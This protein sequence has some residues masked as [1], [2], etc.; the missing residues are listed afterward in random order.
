M[1][2][3]LR[4]RLLAA[5]GRVAEGIGSGVERPVIIVGTGRCGTTLLTDILDSHPALLGYPDEAN[6]LWHPRTYPFDASDVAPAPIE[7]DPEGFTRLSVS[8]W[9]AGHGRTIRR[10]F[11]G[12]RFM[13]GRSKALFVKSAMISFMIPTIQSIFPDLKVIHLYR[14]G[15]SVV[16]SYMKKN[17]GRYGRYRPAEEEYRRLC[18]AY[19]HA[20]IVEIRRACEEAGLGSDRFHEFSYEGLCDD[21][22]GTVDEMAGFLGID[23]DAVAYDLSRIR[24]TNYKVGDWASDPAWKDALAEMRPTM[25]ALG[26]L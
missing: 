17:Y 21:A 1:R 6:D 16:A 10:V 8:Q 25:E 14:N 18:A 11:A 5:A 26:Y 4:G 20:C 9:P 23:P 2:T 12:Y 19:W 15:P 22:T 7:A 24:S 3:Q 13:N